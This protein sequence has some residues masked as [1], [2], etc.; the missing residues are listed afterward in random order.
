MDF[1]SVQTDSGQIGNPSHRKVTIMATNRREFLTIAAGSSL[2]SLAPTIP[3]ILA[4]AALAGEESKEDRVLIVIQLS[5]GNDGLN[6]VVPF[7]NDEYY[8]NRFTLAIGKNQVRKI[9]DDLGFHPAMEGYS[10]LLESNRLAIVQGVG[11]PNPNRSHF[12]SMDLWHTA[13]Q[14]SDRQ[15]YGWLGRYLDGSAGKD[16]RDVAAI[17]FG[18][19][20]QP[21]AL[22]SEITPVPSIQSMDRFKL[23]LGDRRELR[24]TIQKA[25]GIKRSSDNELLSFVQ[26]SA[27]SAIVTA[28]RVEEAQK[29]YKSEVRYPPTSLAHKLRTIAQ[30]IDAGLSTKIYYVTLNGF[31]THSNQ[32]QAHFGLLRELTGATLAFLDDVSNHGHADRVL[33]MTFSEFG[34]R[35]KENASQGTDHGA[36]APLFLAGNNVKPGLIGKHPSLTDL[37]D[38]DVKFHTDYRRVY[39]TLLE[40]WLG[41]KAESVL[42]RQF[43]SLPCLK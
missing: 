16:G 35:V 36:A 7:A 11:Y 17:H 12:E 27:T 23:E 18:K 37:E 24:N 21:L 41:C 38:G 29:N 10:K 1:Q 33:A 6:T 22:S 2:I 34:R 39:A 3:Q 19:E 8:K 9:N 28:E 5:G 13:H 26:Q 43:N 20:K 31:D 15:Q 30:L 40:Q 4:N 32:G 42:G 25:T 14:T